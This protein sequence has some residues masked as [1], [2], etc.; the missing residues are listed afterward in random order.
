MRP[1]ILWFDESY[2]ELYY[3]SDSIRDFCR[4]G[5]DAVIVVGTALETSMAAN[6]VSKALIDDIMVIEVNPEPCLN[7]GNVVHVN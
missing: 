5:L 3:R 6:L 7:E 2:N 4:E 1:N